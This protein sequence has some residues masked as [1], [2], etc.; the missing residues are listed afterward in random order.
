[1]KYAPIPQRDEEIAVAVNGASVEVHRQL[2]PGFLEGIYRKAGSRVVVAGVVDFLR[3]L[4]ALCGSAIMLS[5][6]SDPG[7]FLTKRVLMSLKFPLAS[8]KP[9]EHFQDAQAVMDELLAKGKLVAGEEMYLDAR[10][11]LV[12]AYEDIHYPI[13]PASD[14]DMLRHL[15]E[16]KGVTQA[17]LHRE[18]GLA[19]SSISE[20]LAGRKAFSRR[21]IRKLADHFKVDVS[22]LAS[23]L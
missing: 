11:D 21:M 8:L 3:V 4:C 23:N 7:H 19:K 14:A 1:M 16:A 10:S 9:E 12:A 13:E 17:E 22:V 20:I 6:Q 5:W 15:M 18:T 2:G